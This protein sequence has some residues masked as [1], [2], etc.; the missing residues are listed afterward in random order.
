M[1]CKRERKK[2]RERERDSEEMGE[3]GARD[4]NRTGGPYHTLVLIR[5]VPLTRDTA[6]RK[7]RDIEPFINDRK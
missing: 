4:T 7:I 1:L 6:P 2:E 5:E 3:R